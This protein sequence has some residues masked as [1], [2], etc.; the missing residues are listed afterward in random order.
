VFRCLLLDE[1]VVGSQPANSNGPPSPSGKPLDSVYIS[2]IAQTLAQ[3]YAAPREPGTDVTLAFDERYCSAVS[4]WFERAP[5]RAADELTKDAYRAFKDQTLR[6]YHAM[7]AAGLR[8]E[9]WTAPGQPYKDST[10]LRRQVLATGTVYVYLTRHGHGQDALG[11]SE[12]GP[13]ADHPMREPSDITIS[14]VRLLCNDLFRAV[15]DVFGHVMNGN[16]FSARGEFLATYDH[17]GMYSPD[18]HP[19]LMSETIGQICW[20]YYGPHLRRPDGTL[21][22]AQDLDYVNPSQRPY[23][24]QKTSLFPEDLSRRYYELFRKVNYGPA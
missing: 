22:Q 20:F 15:H 1:R 8:V 3:G 11:E 16:A 5:E 6:Q 9:P 19:V 14:G 24:R 4:E 17:C 12:G 13:S 2:T 10:E 23:P 18:V 7:T 21:P